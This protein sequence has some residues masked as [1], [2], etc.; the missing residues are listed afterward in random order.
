MK[1]FLIENVLF[2]IYVIFSTLSMVY[3]INILLGWY[4]YYSK[5]TTEIDIP[6]KISHIPGI[7]DVV[8][9]CVVILFGFLL[10]LAL[11][12]VFLYLLHITYQKERIKKYFILCF[13]LLL[14]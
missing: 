2:D 11:H 7:S 3:P 10:I 5:P 8:A 6:N 14:M 13:K 4:I 1:K 9:Y 12:G